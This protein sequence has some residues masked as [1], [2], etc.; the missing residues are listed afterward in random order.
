[1][2]VESI[3]VHF[4]PFNLNQL[5]EVKMSKLDQT[6][7]DVKCRVT[8]EVWKKLKVLSVMKEVTIA[9]LVNQVLESFVS[10]KKFEGEESA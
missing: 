8:K 3:K 4:D 7:K 2:T 1:M 9:E 5:K 6:G 10:K